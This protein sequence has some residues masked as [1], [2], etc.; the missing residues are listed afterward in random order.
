VQI[1]SLSIPDIAKT[2]GVSV[3][4]VRVAKAE[5]MLQS[6]K[7]VPEIVSATGLTASKIQ[8]IHIERLLHFGISHEEIAKQTSASMKKILKTENELKDSSPIKPSRIR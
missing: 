6:G 8:T 4:E 2:V 3:G 7:P 5:W 1:D